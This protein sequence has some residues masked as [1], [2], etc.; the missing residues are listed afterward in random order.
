MTAIEV[1]D[2]VIE[3]NGYPLISGLNLTVQEGDRIA[4]VGPPGSGKTL[5]LYALCGL[6]FPFSGEIRVYNEPPRRAWERGLIQ[7]LTPTDLALL[8]A[9]LPAPIILAD[10]PLLN[11]PLSPGQ[12]ILFTA[13]SAKITP[14]P[15]LKTVSLRGE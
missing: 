14:H 3:A 6:I 7:L 12:T 4:I 10:F 15:H 9:S 2:L 5:F 8:T 1:K 13:R 11:F